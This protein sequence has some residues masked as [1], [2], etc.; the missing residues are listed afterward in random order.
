MAVKTM[1]NIATLGKTV[2]E[3]AARKK[4]KKSKK[5]TKRKALRVMTLMHR[6]SHCSEAYIAAK[7]S[8]L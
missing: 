4:E 1:I 2:L 3:F 5:K 6:M 7:R 8:S